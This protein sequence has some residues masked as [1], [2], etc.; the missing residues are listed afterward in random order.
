MFDFDTRRL[1]SVDN[2]KSVMATEYGFLNGILYMAPAKT[3]GVGNLCGAESTGCERLCL[4]MFS[5][6]AAIVAD[7]E[8]GDNAVRRAR[9][10]KGPCVHAATPGV[11]GARRAPD[12]QPGE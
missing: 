3:G 10:A 1:F 8:H 5:G 7:L 9:R 12:R 11:H 2:P 6:Q 4:G